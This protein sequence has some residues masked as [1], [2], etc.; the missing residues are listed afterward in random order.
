MA[1]DIDKDFFNSLSL[2][3]EKTEK[4]EEDLEN[5]EAGI[6][7]AIEYILY[8]KQDVFSESVNKLLVE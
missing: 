5:V 1:D 2:L 4:G 3:L 6:N 7:F 8:I